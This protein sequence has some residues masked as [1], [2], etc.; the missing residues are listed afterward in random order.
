MELNG[1][2]M[3]PKILMVFGPR[4]SILI[5]IH[6]KFSKFVFFSCMFIIDYKKK[7]SCINITI[8]LFK[9]HKKAK[10]TCTPKYGHKFFAFIAVNFGVTNI[11]YVSATIYIQ[12][13]ESY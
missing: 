11:Y 1:N 4:I 7:R 6:L 9:S 13:I 2:L 5:L 8:C 3:E 12:G 10:I